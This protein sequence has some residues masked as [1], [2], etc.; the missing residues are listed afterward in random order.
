[1]G[2]FKYWLRRLVKNPW[3]DLSV[4]GILVIS[5]LFE[6]WETFPQ[7]FTSANFRSEHGVIIF[8]FVMV[9]KALTDMFAGFE[10]MDEAN[11]VEKE[12]VEKE[13]LKN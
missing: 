9:L 13:K 7:D 4:G 1:V 2:R 11:Q 10:F 6:V 8:G 3:L 5:S 12:M